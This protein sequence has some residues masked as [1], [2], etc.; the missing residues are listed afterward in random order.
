MSFFPDQLAIIRGRGVSSPAVAPDPSAAA[1]DSMSHPLTPARLV[2]PSPGPVQVPCCATCVNLQTMH[3][4]T[5]A[6]LGLRYKT[7]YVL[8]A[9][10]IDPT[11]RHLGAWV[12]VRGVGDYQPDGGSEWIPASFFFLDYIIWPN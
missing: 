3:P 8:T 10:A 1:P 9:Y 4:T 5:L 6:R 2:V 11:P 7:Y 12:Q